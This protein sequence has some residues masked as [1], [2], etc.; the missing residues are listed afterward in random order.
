MTFLLPPRRL[1]LIAIS[2]FFALSCSAAQPPQ[3]RKDPTALAAEQDGWRRTVPAPAPAPAL[4][5]PVPKRSLLKNQLSVL[6]VHK[7]GLPLCHISLVLKSGS[8]QD[9]HA[10]PGVAQFT[11]DMLKLGTAQHSAAELAEAIENLGT[12][13]GVGVSEDAIVL[14]TT[15]LSENIEAAFSLLAEQVRQPRFAASEIERLRRTRLAELAQQ[16]FDPGTSAQAVFRQTLYGAHP[17]GHLPRGRAQSVKRIGAA[18]IRHYYKEHF[19][20]ANAAMVVV[21]DLSEEKALALA[22]AHLGTWSADPEAPSGPQLPTES[23]Q[24]HR[25]GISLVARPGAPQSQIVVGELGAA[26]SSPD[27]YALTLMN[28]ILGG[29]FNSRINMNLREDKGYTYGAHSSFDFMRQ[30][31][32]F[33][34]YAGVKSATTGA[35]LTEI[36]KEIDRMRKTEVTADELQSA[37]S[38]YSLTLPGK[39]QTVDST[40]GMLAG[41]FLYDLRLDYFTMLPEKINAVSLADVHHVADVYLRPEAMGIVVVGDPKLVHDDLVNLGRGKVTL[42]TS[43]GRPVE[44]AHAAGQRGKLPGRPAP[45]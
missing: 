29:Q 16:D 4:H 5:A 13:I 28:A 43:D 31:G 2:S 1:P 41:L 30:R 44:P 42:R 34:V 10:L 33:E 35:S 21:G 45:R 3:Q 20:P 7:P 37:Q 17:Y 12:Q 39:F 38:H 14:S 9:P 18:S 22:E 40:G 23:P 36:F 11:A 25:P 32:P 6:S 26:H 19:R 15:A 8:A 27:F 24:E